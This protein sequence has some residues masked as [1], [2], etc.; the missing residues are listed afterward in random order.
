ML[1]GWLEVLSEGDTTSVASLEALVDKDTTLV[2][3]V[4][5]LRGDTILVG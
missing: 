3:S 5:A 4:D 2:G 1:V